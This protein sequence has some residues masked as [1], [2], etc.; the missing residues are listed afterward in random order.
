MAVSEFFAYMAESY[1]FFVFDSVLW[2]CDLKSNMADIY[3]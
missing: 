3:L 1:D 2:G